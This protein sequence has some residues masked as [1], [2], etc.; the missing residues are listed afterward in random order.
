MSLIVRWVVHALVLWLVAFILPG[1]TFANNW[2][3]LVTVIV[4][5]LINALI[6]PVI[7]LLTLPINLFTLGLFTLVI[8]ALMFWLASTV[9]KGFEVEGFGAAFLGALLYSLLAM[10]VNSAKP[11]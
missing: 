3:L 6:R 10:L 7:I 1:V 4:L 9:V 8:N 2:S 11:K 5:G